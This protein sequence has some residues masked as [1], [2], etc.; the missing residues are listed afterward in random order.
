MVYQILR[1]SVLFCRVFSLVL[2]KE[3]W[4]KF[5]EWNFERVRLGLDNR[6][7]NSE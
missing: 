2:M 5:E 3:Y 7:L 1:H 6:G 4:E